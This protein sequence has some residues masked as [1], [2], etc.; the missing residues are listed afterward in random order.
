MVRFVIALAS[1]LVVSSVTILAQNQVQDVQMV[2][3]LRLWKPS[4]GD[5]AKMP[6][7][8]Q[9]GVAGTYL[10]TPFSSGSA[11]AT[12]VPTYLLAPSVSFSF[13][14]HVGH[15][16]EI[17]G[18]AQAAP[19]RATVPAQRPEESSSTDSMP[20]LTVSAMKMVSEGCP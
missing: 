13:W 10:L 18:T 12:Y 2:G 3:C 8:R 7:E 11:T 4:T 6:S 15:K 20:R 19:L 9:P 1:A 16:V 5:P 17:T 14:H